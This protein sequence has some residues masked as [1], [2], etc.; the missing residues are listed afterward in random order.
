MGKIRNGVSPTG[1]DLACKF[2]ASRANL[3][4]GKSS[5]NTWV[6]AARIELIECNDDLPYARFK[7]LV[8][9]RH[10]SNSRLDEGLSLFQNSFGHL[11]FPSR[12]VMIKA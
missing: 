10:V 5:Q 8:G 12:K 11:L 7:G 6:L 2:L 1:E 9:L 4:N 3:G